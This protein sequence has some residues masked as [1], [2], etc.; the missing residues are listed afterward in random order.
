MSSDHR[1][2]QDDPCSPVFLPEESVD[3]IGGHRLGTVPVDSFIQ[4]A[5]DDVRQ[6][7]TGSPKWLP[8]RLFYDSTGSALFESITRLPEYYLT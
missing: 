1:V 3:H 4:S 7:L 6:G 8:S 2:I 5:E